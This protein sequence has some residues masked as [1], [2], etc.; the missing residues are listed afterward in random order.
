MHRSKESLPTRLLRLLARSIYS[1]PRFFFYPQAL[2]VLACLSYTIARLEFSTSRNDLVG[3]EKRYHQNFLNYKKEF[4][5][6]DDLVAVIESEN[7]EKNRQF[8]ERLGAKLEAESNMF[9]DVFFKGDLAMMGPKALLFLPETTL[10]QLLETL[11]QYRPFIQ[12]FGQATN[13]GSLFR[14]INEQFRTAERNGASENESL[15]KALPAITRIVR[16]ATDSLK[17]PGTPPSPGI[18]ALF[19]DNGQASQEQ[20]ITFA[21]GRINLVSAIVPEDIPSGHAISRLRELVRETQIEVPGVNVGI[22]GETV[23]EYDEMQQARKDSTMASIAALVLV[24]IIFVSAY[25]EI[26]RPLKATA[27]LLVGLIYTLGYTT[28]TVGHLNILTV[29]FLPILIGLAIDFGVHLITR[30][31]EELRNGEPEQIALEKAL[32][33]TGSGIFTGCFTTSGAFFAMALTDFKGIQEMGIITG[34]GMLICLVPMLTLLPVLLRSE[35]AHSPA[36]RLSIPNRRANIER[37]WMERPAIIVTAGIVLC[38]LAVTQFPKVYF[39]Y[40]LLNMQSKGLSAVVFEKKLIENATKSVLFAAVIADSA[41]E[42]A[43]L[44]FDISNLSSAASIDSMSRFLT[45]DQ[46]GKFPKVGQIKEAIQSLEFSELDSRPVDLSELSQTLYYTQGWLGFASRQIPDDKKASV[47]VALDTLREAITELRA[48]IVN[49]DS[50]QVASKMK[51]FQDALFSDIR[52]TFGSLMRQENRDPLRIKDLPEPLKHRF[53]GINGKHLLQVYPKGN[54][55]ERDEQELF[56]SQ[57]RTID[58]NVTGTPVQLLEYTTLLKASYVEAAWYSLAAIVILVFMHFGTVSS[59]FLGL[60]PVAVGTIWMIGVMGALQIP[61]N[62]ANIMTLP[63]VI[64]IGVTNGIHILSRVVEEGTG[65]ILG[66]STGKAVV[67]SGLTT[68]AGFASL[69]PAKHQGISSLGIVM[70]VGVGACMV[71]A[72]TILPALISLNTSFVTGQKKPSGDNARST[73]GREEPR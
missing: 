67:I 39:D 70:S 69:I 40:N 19:G 10:D 34:G 59:V 71:A 5:V 47:A 32:V 37:L 26:G 52:N 21:N 11:K 9:Q 61:F 14:K 7:T 15:L 41:K 54:V 44:E 33:N 35:K 48:G 55:W 65:R 31:E 45:E 51:A 29:T 53:I 24:G 38:G 68:I 72:L 42:A 22:T 49:D 3:S 60:L 23:L 56:V 17:R 4:Q 62:P 20:Y 36:H 2:L 64:G 43:D 63:L 46:T 27:C 50:R 1:H 6:R 8:A 12:D 28:L 16:Q 13:I 58:P 30:Y 66:K 73:L 57:L 18:T 25:R